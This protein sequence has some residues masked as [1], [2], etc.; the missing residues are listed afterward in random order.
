MTLKRSHHCV[1]E[2][3]YHFVFP[4][5]Y[6]KA[7]LDKEIERYFIEICR[8]IQERYG[9]EFEEVG[10]DIDHVHVLCSA[11][12]KYSPTEVVT[13]IKSLTAR[14]ILKRF[15]RLRRELWGGEL[16]TEGYYVATI[17]EGGNKEVIQQYVR[18]QG[19]KPEEVQLR[20]FP[21]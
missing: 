4:V 19:K 13:I 17:G 3:H 9:I 5:K 1:Y 14:E 12:P 15:G 11:L 2:I 21:F 8:G 6:R 16:W 18:N 10:L 20:L 7:L